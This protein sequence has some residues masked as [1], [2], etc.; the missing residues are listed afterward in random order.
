[1][2]LRQKPTKICACYRVR[3]FGGY[4]MNAILTL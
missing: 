4:Y 3:E 1:M 2:K